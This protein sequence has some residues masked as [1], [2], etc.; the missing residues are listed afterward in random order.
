[1]TFEQW[2]LFVAIWFAASLPLGPNALNCISVSANS[3][4]QRSLWTIVG[5]LIA[6]IC[7]MAA[8]VLGF[9]A[10]TTISAD[11]FQILKIFGAAY[12]IWMGLSLWRNGTR[13]HEQ[14]RGN[15]T[16]WRRT[17]LRAALISISNPKAIFSYVAI[18]SQFIEPDKLLAEQLVI[19]MPTSF[20]ISILVYGGYCTLGI[21]VTKVLRTA[22]RRITFNRATAAFYIMIGAG[23]VFSDHQALHPKTP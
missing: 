12:L 18:F 16:K 13:F 5:I 10:I 3:G 4:F 1:M 17:V 20:A 8:T 23:L 14:S 11:L 9:A 19:L 7:H 15:N 21:T 22:R 2:L 6:S